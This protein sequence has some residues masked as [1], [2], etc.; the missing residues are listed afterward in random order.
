MKVSEL[1]EKL[2]RAPQDADVW[3]EGCDCDG[4]CAFVLVHADGTVMLARPDASYANGQCGP[5]VQL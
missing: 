1:I 5:S 3:T 2:Q 4:E